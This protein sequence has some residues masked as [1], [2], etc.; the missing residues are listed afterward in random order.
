MNELVSIIVPVYNVSQYLSVC[1]ESI[2]SQTHKAIE[3]FLIDDGSDDGSDL[4]CDN[5]AKKDSRIIVIHQK[6]HGVSYSRN[7]GINLSK[8]LILYFSYQS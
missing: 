3:I 5:Y 6:N 7:V 1:I 4:I 2:L 8:G